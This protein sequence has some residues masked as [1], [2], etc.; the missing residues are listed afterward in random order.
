IPDEISS[1]GADETFILLSPSPQVPASQRFFPPAAS[2]DRGNPPL[3]RK[4][5]S[6]SLEESVDSDEEDKLHSV[7]VSELA[8]LYRYTSRARRILHYREVSEESRNYYLGLLSRYEK[9]EDAIHQT[10]RQLESDIKFREFC[11]TAR[12]VCR[13]S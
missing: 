11:R 13:R 8:D 2:S 9:S 7:L 10:L 12:K 6:E 3:S 4:R 1:A 5:S